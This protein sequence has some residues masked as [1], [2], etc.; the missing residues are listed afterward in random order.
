M[1]THFI[2][3]IL[4]FTLCEGFVYAL[5][6][7]HGSTST[8]LRRSRH[9]ALLRRLDSDLDGVV[10]SLLSRRQEQPPVAPSGP[11]ASGTAATGATTDP[12]KWEL[13]TQKACM[14]A[15]RALNSTIISPCGIAFCYNLPFLDNST[16]VFQAD[17]RLYRVAAPGGAWAGIADGDV[18]VDLDFIGASVTMMKE[19]IKRSDSDGLFTMPLGK[20]QQPDQPEMLQG[21]SFIGQMNTEALS[22]AIDKNQLQNYLLPNVTLSALTPSQQPLKTTLASAD[23][24]FVNGVLSQPADTCR[25][26]DAAASAGPFAMPGMRLAVF[27]IGLVITGC[28]ALIGIVVVAAGTVERYQFREQY[29]RRKAREGKMAMRTI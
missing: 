26:C 17:L 12:N 8:L 29:R 25:A 4:F 11:T 13:D 18:N 24:S 10:D 7:P 28:W 6:T 16:G 19:K 20:R 21:F 23:G 27:P 5:Y 14:D 2:S 9:N 15:M 22:K 3:L 1:H